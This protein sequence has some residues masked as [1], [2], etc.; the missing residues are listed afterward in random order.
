MN[1]FK[2]WTIQKMSSLSHR[3]L[4]KYDEDYR[5][6]KIAERKRMRKEMQDEIMKA[7]AVTPLKAHLSKDNKSICFYKEESI[8][9]LHKGGI[10]PKDKIIKYD[11]H[12]G[13][14]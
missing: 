2:F 5:N 11:P 14:D 7:W 4:Y 8:P 3:I 6:W 9:K 13:R 10:I 1:K 12:G